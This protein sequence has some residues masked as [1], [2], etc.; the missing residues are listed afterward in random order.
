MSEKRVI[1][2][3]DLSLLD[4]LAVDARSTINGLSE[5]LNFPPTTVYYRLKKLER[6]RVIRGY[7]V[8][9]DPEVLGLSRVIT[10]MRIALDKV[11]SVISEL[12][13][14]DNVVEVYR[15]MGCCDVVAS[16]MAR[17]LKTLSLLEEKIA[18]IEGVRGFESLVTIKEHK[19]RP[20]PKVI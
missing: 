8:V 11:D 10:L 17:D 3:L 18:N 14:L 6:L 5:K 7:T 16:L 19:K 15:V 1:D 20:L 12:T 4:L 2:A 9:V 13:R